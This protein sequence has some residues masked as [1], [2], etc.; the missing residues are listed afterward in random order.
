MTL[1]ENRVRIENSYELLKRFENE[2]LGKSFYDVL[3]EGF[4][5]GAKK[6][7][8][9]IINYIDFELL[10]FLWEVKSGSTDLSMMSVFHSDISVGLYSIVNSINQLEKEHP[11]EIR[12]DLFKSYL[13]LNEF[14]SEPMVAIKKILVSPLLRTSQIEFI[15]EFFAHESCLK[16]ENSSFEIVRKP[17]FHFKYKQF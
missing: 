8:F 15:Q 7:M 10:P 1:E 4:S 17:F 16:E 2:K 13:A 11:R 3:T 9:P 6:P 12:N 14:L 5:S